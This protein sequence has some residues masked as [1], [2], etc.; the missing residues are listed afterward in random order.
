MYH[1]FRN[2]TQRAELAELIDRAQGPARAD[3]VTEEVGDADEHPLPSAFEG[4]IEPR[5]NVRFEQFSRAW[6]FVRGGS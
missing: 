6:D 4:V 1:E 2:C 5:R 3:S